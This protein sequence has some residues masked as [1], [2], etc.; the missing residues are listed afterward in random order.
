[1]SK[2]WTPKPPPAGR[3]YFDKQEK[4]KVPRFEDTFKLAGKSLNAAETQRMIEEYKKYFYQKFDNNMFGTPE[5]KNPPQPDAKLASMRDSVKQWLK[6]SDFEVE[7]DEVVGNEAAKVALREAVEASTTHAELYAFYK[8]QAPGGVLLFGGPGNGK[9]MLAKAVATS[10]NK[11]FGG[12]GEM[13]ML[14]GPELQSKWYGETEKYIRSIFAYAREYYLVRKRPLP[15]FM[16]EAD[17]ML[18]VRSGRRW[19]DDV[20]SQ[21][22]SEMDGM[23][24][25]GAFLILASNRPDSIDPAILRDGRIDRKIKVERPNE[26]DTKTLFQMHLVRGF[27]EGWAPNGFSLDPVIEYLHSPD[28]LIQVLHNPQSGASHHFNLSHIVSGAML[29]GIIQRAKTHA[30][31]RDRDAGTM[32]GLVQADLLAAILE[33]YGENKDLDHSYALREFV[34]EVALPAEARANLKGLN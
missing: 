2:R 27:E 19:T 12:E 4:K 33:V 17:S 29:V 34:E 3:N 16:D 1:M 10:L 23:Q 18:H 14:S 20:V 15:I 30:F 28:H 9:T 8:M 24:K 26:A 31:H 6:T 21:F 11:H 5:T 13:I 32:N 22:L 7:W 25:N